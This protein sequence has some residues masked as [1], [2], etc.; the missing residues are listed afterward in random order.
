MGATE[1]EVYHGVM[2]LIGAT[3]TSCSIAVEHLA[4]RMD[5]VV[6]AYVDRAT[7]TIHVAYNDEAVL[8]KISEFVDHLGY[9]A[10][11]RDKASSEAFR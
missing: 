6:D 1:K 7:H 8:Q 4:K 5:G 10:T 3:C 2:D 11:I 9:K